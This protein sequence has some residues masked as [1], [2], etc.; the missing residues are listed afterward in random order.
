MTT[1][2]W[3]IAV[4][5]ADFERVVLEGSRERPVVVDFWAPWC[6][7]CR[8][9]GPVLERLAV[10]H[11]GAFLLAKVDV[12]Q[13]PA[14]AE[15]LKVQSIPAVKAF[16][17]GRIVAEFVGA[18][19]EPAVRTF[20]ATVL[21]SEADKLA[22][23]GEGY[24]AGDATAAEAAFRGALEHD[25]R[26][27]RALMGLARLLAARGETTEALALLQRVVAEG[28][29]ARDA[30]RLAAELRTRAGVDGGDP[31]ALRAAVAAEP[32]NLD[33]RLELG[34]LLAARGAYA[35]ALAE[36]LEVVRREPRH[37]DG[38][39]RQAMVDI[40]AVLGARDPL[41][42]RYRSHLAQA[43]FR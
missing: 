11:E 4:G 31:T 36:L 14:V 7:P 26:H 42:E 12:D 41:T 1:S 29:V 22:A 21:P 8:T 6:A 15:A 17:E 20:L 32:T 37:A 27:A 39:A 23:E 28:S 3:V 34:R 2:A 9:L 43:L 33:A 40:F 30:E 19:P 38:A 25:P 16:R 24:A 18:Q 10:E 35:D 13:A 5:D